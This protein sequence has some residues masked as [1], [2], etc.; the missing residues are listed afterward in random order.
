[1]NILVLVQQQ[2]VKSM[3]LFNFPSYFGPFND[4][5]LMISRK[6][7]PS[8]IEPCKHTEESQFLLNNTT[9]DDVNKMRPKIFVCATMWHE[10]LEEMKILL[11]SIFRLDYDHAIRRLDYKNE[12]NFELDAHIFFDDAFESIDRRGKDLNSFVHTFHCAINE[13]AREHYLLETGMKHN[14]CITPYGCRKV[15]T[16]PG[17]TKL[18]VHLKDKELIRNK[19]RWSQ[20]MYFNYILKQKVT[21]ISKESNLDKQNVEENIYILTLDGDVSFTPLNVRKIFIKMQE[22]PEIGAVTGRLVP[23]GSGP[24]VWFQIF[25]YAIEHWLWK[26]AENVFGSVLCA[27]GCFSLYRGSAILSNRV[28]NT[29]SRIPS[30]PREYL[31]FDQ[32]E[33][34]WLTTLLLKEGYRVE[35]IDDATVFTAAPE[36]IPEFLK[37]RRRWTSSIIANLLDLQECSKILRKQNSAIS[38]IFIVYIFIL[39]GI[40]IFTP[41]AL[42]LLLIEVTLQSLTI[43]QPWVVYAVTYTPF[44]IHFLVCFKVKSKDTEHT[45]IVFFIFIGHI[46]ALIHK[47]VSRTW[48]LFLLPYLIPAFLHISHFHHLVYIGAFYVL[49]PLC[50]ILLY[51]YSVCNLNDMSWGTREKKTN[52]FNNKSLLENNETILNIYHDI[53]SDN[54]K[55]HSFF[56]SLKSLIIIKLIESMHKTKFNYLTECDSKRMRKQRHL[57]VS[58]KEFWQI[59]IKETLYPIKI[60]DNTKSSLMKDFQICRNRW[61]TGYVFLNCGILIFRKCLDVL[62]I[63]LDITILSFTFKPF[64]LLNIIIFGFVT[65]FQLT[66]LVIFK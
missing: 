28:L 66:G 51:T 34:R 14:D 22:S 48:Y 49:S 61:V 58:E 31:Q 40:T 29:Y 7:E 27:P 2:Q 55:K 65:L 57:L 50:Y 18:T 21:E 43:V 5:S 53:Q 38:M 59:L 47:G 9:Y 13:V 36:N 23:C 10:T 44:L 16:L 37:Q 15:W 3:S 8:R 4:I 26:T 1:M 12:D 25:E 11:T 30:T 54:D 39:V 32:G 24:I 6:Q 46:S 41:A 20:V 63:K 60:E 33:D 17:K 52:R 19:K 42:L 45:C 56:K 64:G 35:Y 62:K